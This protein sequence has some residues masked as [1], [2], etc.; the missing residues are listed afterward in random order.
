MDMNGHD[1]RWIPELLEKVSK[2]RG[3]STLNICHAL[4]DCLEIAISRYYGYHVETTVIIN[5]ESGDV[6]ISLSSRFEERDLSINKIPKWLILQVKQ[7]LPEFIKSHEVSQ[8]YNYWRSYKYTAREGIII[9][10]T[11]A[12]VDVD[13]GSQIGFMQKHHFISN[14]R[15]V[16]GQLKWFYMQGIYRKGT[17]RISRN[18]RNLPAAILREKVPWGNFTCLKRYPGVK[19]YVSSDVYLNKKVIREVSQEL[20]EVI[21]IKV[22]R[23]SPATTAP[24]QKKVALR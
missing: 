8:R 9:R 22:Q 21:I 11:N 5:A 19:S 7:L 3:V 6:N 12:L 13:L 10:A 18:A 23:I 1:H 14:E 20:G 4:E 15:Y 2:E 17:I 16:Q 24:F